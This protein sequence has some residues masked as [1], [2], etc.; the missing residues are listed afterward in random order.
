METFDKCT[1][2]ARRDNVFRVGDGFSLFLTS[3]TSLGASSG[4]YPGNVG[5]FPPSGNQ[6]LFSDKFED[7][8]GT[9]TSDHGGAGTDGFGVGKV[10]SFDV[11]GRRCTRPALEP[12]PP[13]RECH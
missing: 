6:Y 10:L 3:P 4:N 9:L 1:S 5:Q 8:A 2:R 7:I 11:Y 13:Y 12:R